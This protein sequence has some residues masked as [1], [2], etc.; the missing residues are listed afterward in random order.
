VKAVKETQD[1]ESKDVKFPFLRPFTSFVG[2]VSINVKP[3]SNVSF[4]SESRLSRIEP[5]AFQECSSLSSFWIPPARVW[6]KRPGQP[7]TAKRL[8]LV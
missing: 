1:P 3:L 2:T 8:E 4:E 5:A 7:K 6:E